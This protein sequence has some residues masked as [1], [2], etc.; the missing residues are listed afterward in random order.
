MFCTICLRRASPASTL[1]HRNLIPLSQP[2]KVVP[3][4]KFKHFILLG[5]NACRRRGRSGEAASLTSPSLSLLSS[6]SFSLSLY[7]S[8]PRFT[9]NHKRSIVTRLHH[10]LFKDWSF[11]HCVSFFCFLIFLHCLSE[12]PP[13]WELPLKWSNWLFSC[14]FVF[15]QS[16]FL[17]L[18]FSSSLCVG[19]D[20]LDSR[21]LG[22]DF[23]PESCWLV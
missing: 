7:L 6:L 13:C 2:V 12:R 8:F 23:G 17:D 20:G 14:L 15:F 19:Q 3:Q 1:L 9:F 16:T 4:M 10:F 22:E 11:C 18:C 5:G 21:Y